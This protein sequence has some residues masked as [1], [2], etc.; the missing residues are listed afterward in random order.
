MGLFD[1]NTGTCLRVNLFSEF[2]NKHQIKMQTL[3]ERVI[4]MNLSLRT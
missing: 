2:A 4:T 1:L 3:E